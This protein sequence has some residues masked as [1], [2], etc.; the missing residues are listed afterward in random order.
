[1]FACVTR[2]ALHLD[3]A[4]RLDGLLGTVERTNA[5]PLADDVVILAVSR[6]LAAAPAV[7]RN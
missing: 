5:G 1:M 7:S 4:Q 2:E 6:V 3:A